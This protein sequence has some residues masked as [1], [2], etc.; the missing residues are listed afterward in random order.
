MSALARAL[1]HIV[2]H[3]TRA[4]EGSVAIEFGFVAVPFFLLLVGLAEVSMVGLM[5]TNL[6]HAVNIRARE[7]RTGEAQRNGVTYDEMHD[8]ICERITNLLSVDC[9][10]NL[11]LD[12]Q[13]FDSFLDAS[14]AAVTPLA[15]A[16]QPGDFVPGAPSE[17]VVVRAYYRWEVLT[18]L[19][20]TIFA[21]MAGGER[22]LVSTMMFRNEPYE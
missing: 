16:M 9:E 15:D 1:R 21:N 20:E 12:V 5:Q 18:P 6:D 4:R 14:N 11:F 19:F 13:V 7:I 3:F 17:I 8:A 22:V 2:K 10:A